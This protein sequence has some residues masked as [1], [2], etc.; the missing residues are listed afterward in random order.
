MWGFVLNKISLRHTHNHLPFSLRFDL[1][2]HLD[3]A[4]S[5]MSDKISRSAVG[6]QHDGYFNIGVGTCQQS[7]LGFGKFMG[8]GSVASTPAGKSGRSSGGK[9]VKR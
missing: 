1:I 3:L 7:D 5:Q 2:R 9:I 8:G 6:D 4:A